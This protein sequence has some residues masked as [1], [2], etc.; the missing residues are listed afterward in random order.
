MQL[1]RRRFLGLC[2]T[3]L[4][5]TTVTAVPT[6]ANREALEG[7]WR[8]PRFDSGRTGYNPTASGPTGEELNRDWQY[9]GIS[10]R[11]TPIVTGDQVL[12]PDPDY[13]RAVDRL[14]GTQRWEALVG[15]GIM[16]LAVEAD[17]LC[18]VEFEGGDLVGLAVEDGDRLWTHSP[19][20]PATAPTGANGRFHVGVSEGLLTVDASDGSHDWTADLDGTLSSP[21]AAE[22]DVY[23]ATSTTIYRIGADD[24]EVVWEQDFLTAGPLSP[25][26]AGDTLYAG[27]VAERPGQPRLV[28]LETADGSERWRVDRYTQL[29]DPA[30]TSERAFVGGEAG[31]SPGVFA[32]DAA[33]G[34]EDWRQILDAP[35]VAPPVVDAERVYVATEDGSLTA[36]DRSH[37]GEQST[38]QVSETDYP[39]QPV[40]VGEQV[41]VCTPDDGLISLSAVE[42]ESGQTD[43]EAAADAEADEDDA[44]DSANDDGFGP[45]FDALGALA[46]ISGLAYLLSRHRQDRERQN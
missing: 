42:Q 13:V 36:L 16:P 38:W 32:L 14:D 19:T 41:Y 6:A 29:T 11:S 20:F 34:G 39:G 45:G 23:A 27:D 5:S 37:G 22:G 46:G 1:D 3:G 12:L 8:Q 25:V 26:V 24:G 31:G 40:V 44:D 7:E 4:A 28:A 33:D 18:A 10:S 2:G 17:V 21:V 35:V 43:Q 15:E 30:V 9:E